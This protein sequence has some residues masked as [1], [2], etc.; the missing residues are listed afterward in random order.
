ML[1]MGFVRYIVRHF[2]RAVQ[3]YGVRRNNFV[4][5]MGSG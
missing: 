5:Q 2:W 3:A 1:T 4:R